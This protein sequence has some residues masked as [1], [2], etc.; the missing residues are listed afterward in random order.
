MDKFN[1]AADGD[2]V[3]KTIRKHRSKRDSFYGSV[4]NIGGT[5]P[6]GF[7]IFRAQPETA[8]HAKTYGPV[9]I[10]FMSNVGMRRQPCVV[11]AFGALPVVDQIGHRADGAEADLNLGAVNLCDTGRV[12]RNGRSIVGT[13]HKGAAQSVTA[14]T[15]FVQS[16]T[17]SHDRLRSGQQQTQA[18]SSSEKM[19]LHFSPLQSNAAGMHEKSAQKHSPRDSPR[20]AAKSA[21]VLSLARC[22]KA[23][24]NRAPA[25]ALRS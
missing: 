25:P 2:G 8:V 22:T 14:G 15:P 20:A 7:F 1:A 9:V 16:K 11:G 10:E 24:R 6:S 17:G 12:E 18:E 21:T 4:I 13:S 5:G 19:S 23:Q 3:C